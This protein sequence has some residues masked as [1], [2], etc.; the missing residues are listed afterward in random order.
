[1]KAKSGFPFFGG[2]TTPGIRAPN[3]N[4]T[5]IFSQSNR[6]TMRTSRPLWEGAS[7][8]INW[9]LGWSYNVNRTIQ[10]DSLGFTLEN[11]KVVS[12]DVDRSFLSFPAFPA[13]KLLNTS[14]TEVQRLYVLARDNPDDSRSNDA[15]IAEAFENGLEALPLGKKIFGNLFPRPNWTIRWDGIEKLWLLSSIASRISF[16]HS[17]SSGYKLRWHVSPSGEQVT[18]SQQATYGFSPLIGLNITFKQ[19]AKGNFTATIRYGLTTSYDL[20]PSNQN[21]VQADRSEIS[22]SAQFTRQGFEIPFFG[23][24]L[25]NDIDISLTYGYTKDSKRVYDLKTDPFKP[26]G[27]PL[28][29][30]SQSR[31]EPRIRYILSSRVTASVYY[32]YMKLKPDEGGSRI[33]G[34]TT[35][36]GG[37]DIRVAIQP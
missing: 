18:E 10:S 14:I 22:V 29:G 36:E 34:S 15:K 20:T 7:L 19:L 11:N 5:D 35:N 27:T 28:E 1:M 23:L 3:G 32:K 12:G 8:E 21:I 13:F 25:S 2:F 9:N 31:I 37:L 24:S 16:D 4:L 33:P 26:E 6:I 30:Q 17:Y